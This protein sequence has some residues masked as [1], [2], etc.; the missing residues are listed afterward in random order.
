MLCCCCF[1]FFCFC[2]W[3]HS[4]FAPCVVRAVSFSRSLSCS[5]HLH[6]ALREEVQLAAGP[7]DV[8]LRQP[9]RLAPRL[10]AAQGVDSLDPLVPLADG[11]AV[12]GRRRLQVLRPVDIRLKGALAHLLLRQVLPRLRQPRLPPLVPVQV[13]AEDLAGGPR[14]G[15]R[16]HPVR[17][18]RLELIPLLLVPRPLAPPRVLLV[19]RRQQRHARPC[20]PAARAPPQ[21]RRRVP[22]LVE[23]LRLLQH[24]GRERVVQ[25]LALQAAQRRLRLD[26]V[27][28]LRETA[29]AA[30]AL[31]LQVGEQRRVRTERRPTCLP[32]L[33]LLRTL[34][35]Q[36]LHA[37]L[38]LGTPLRELLPHRRGAAAASAAACATGAAAG[39]SRRPAAAACRKQAAVRLRVDTRLEE[40]LAR[41]GVRGGGG[42]SGGSGSGRRRAQ[43]LHVQR[44]ARGRRRRSLLH[45]TQPFGGPCAR[46]RRPA[47]RRPPPPPPQVQRRRRRRRRCR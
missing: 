16:V 44:A 21:R 10:A 27:R 7:S 12:P 47:R 34:R 4:Y 36:P 11:G 9:A 42:G 18:Q 32:R 17:L 31:R 35:L 43:V 13:V 39:R 26:V 14:H 2:F 46:R 40:F 28:L 38:L 45:H 29:P 6:N 25:L 15:A 20:A 33:L 3:F 19:L 24:G 37:A 1:F 22:P 23:P 8:R 5:R 41:C 30:L